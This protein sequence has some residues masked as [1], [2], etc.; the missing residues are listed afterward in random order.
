MSIIDNVLANKDID[1]NVIADMFKRCI[2]RVFFKNTEYVQKCFRIPGYSSGY[3][4]LFILPLDLNSKTRV[5][6]SMY[7]GKGRFAGVETLQNAEVI[8][9][10]FGY[11]ECS[12]GRFVC[13]DGDF[14]CTDIDFIDNI[15]FALHGNYTVVNQDIDDQH[16]DLRMLSIDIL[17]DEI[18]AGLKNVFYYALIEDWTQ[19][20]IALQAMS[21]AKGNVIAK[22]N[23]VKP[24]KK[25]SGHYSIKVFKL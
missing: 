15:C 19:F 1:F 22:N 11:L 16:I 20:Y 5:S 17:E 23:K 3:P 21:H 14:I 7:K 10:D 8:V 9:R 12:N 13:S 24:I 2:A 4:G 18:Y 6:L 25:S